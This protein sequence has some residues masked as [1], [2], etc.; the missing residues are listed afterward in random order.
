MSIATHGIPGKCPF[1]NSKNTDYFMLLVSEKS[2]FT[3]IFCNDCHAFN[4]MSFPRLPKNHNF[5]MFTHEEYK[6]HQKK[7]ALRLGLDST[8]PKNTN[9]TE[10]L[11]PTPQLA[12]A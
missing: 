2:G 5:K 4:T 11:L 3:E 7:R 9:F 10:P 12:N 1:C 8:E 6:S